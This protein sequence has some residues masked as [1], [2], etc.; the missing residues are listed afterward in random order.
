MSAFHLSAGMHTHMGR[1]SE[2]PCFLTLGNRHW[3]RDNGEPDIALGVWY[4]VRTSGLDHL[5]AENKTESF[6]NSIVRSVIASMYDR[7]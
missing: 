6:I 7:F 5:G 4:N 3:E 2:S 1:V